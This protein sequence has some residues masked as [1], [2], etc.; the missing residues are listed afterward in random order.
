[1]KTIVLDRD[2]V[3]NQDSDDY[4]KSAEEFVPIAGSIEAIAKLSAAGFRVFIA[5]NQSGL[6]RKYFDED[7]L[8]EIHHLLCSM[9]EQLGGT[10]DGIFYCPHHPD[11]NC[12]CR[13]PR[14]G[15]LEQIESEFACELAGSYFVGDS[16]NDIQVAEAFGC[17]PILV[18]TGKG[19]LTESVLESNGVADVRVYENLSSAI[20]DILEV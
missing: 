7:I 4:I 1:M 19:T 8:S 11:D 9:V 10:I 6:A 14:I 16:L 2:G 18:R 17:K 20:A 3:I 13:K 5:T 12:N 15:L